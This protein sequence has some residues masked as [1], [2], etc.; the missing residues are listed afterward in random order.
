VIE[1]M[2]DIMAGKMVNGGSREKRSSKKIRRGVR[3]CPVC[4]GSLEYVGVTSPNKFFLPFPDVN[5]A[6]RYV[7]SN[8]N[9]VGPIAIN[10]KSREDIKKIKQNFERMKREGKIDN[11]IITQP[12]FHKNYLWFFRLFLILIF[13]I[14]V[15]IL[16]SYIFA[17]VFS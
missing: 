3:V 2:S 14:P 17:G 11:K 13:V 7:C 4:G 10:A 15:L 12:I 1:G 9:Y 6:Q 16:I 8:C 5:T